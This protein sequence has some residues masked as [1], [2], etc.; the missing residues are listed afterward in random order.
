MQSN[1]LEFRNQPVRCRG[2]N[3]WERLRSDLCAFALLTGLIPPWANCQAAPLNNI[4]L[5]QV[6]PLTGA[7]STTGQ[8]VLAGATAAVGREN[9]AGGILGRR[10]RL[11]SV[12]DESDAER[13]TAALQNGMRGLDVLALV[14]CVDD[15]A[16][17]SVLKVGE[18]AG[19]PLFGPL[20]GARF[21]SASRD[22]R[23][24]Q[25][26]ADYQREATALLAQLQSMTARHAAIL[27]D[28][29]NGAEREEV[30]ST[31]LSKV[32]IQTITVRMEVSPEGA[33]AALKTIS[34]SDAQVLVLAVGSS[35]INAL[36]AAA[37]N[38]GLTLPPTLLAFGSPGITELGKMFRQRAFGFSSLVPYPETSQ[39]K[40]ARELLEDAERFSGPEAIT[41]EGLEAYLNVRALAEILRRQ[42]PS[43]GKVITWPTSTGT[44]DL[45]GFRLDLGRL[46]LPASDWVRIG[47]RTR[48]GLIRY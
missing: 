35:A 21:E 11:V 26:R 23:V 42:P 30:I 43:Y 14:N 13:T 22:R 12:D 37:D 7:A 32:G 25:L 10:L 9:A 18:T 41:F 34:K 27:S 8:R 19:V 33:K 29:T 20:S 1:N 6:L 36:A 45:G 39:L 40:L 15:L 48:D 17:W 47:V 16:C 4:V 31:M 46:P 5:V 3:F 24:I 44:L 38:S 28:G 2:R